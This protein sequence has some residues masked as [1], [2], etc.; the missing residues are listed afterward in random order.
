[1]DINDWME[2]MQVEQLRT[3]IQTHLAPTRLEA[4]NQSAIELLKVIFG[5]NI[6]YKHELDLTPTVQISA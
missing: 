2:A 3:W 4:I 6:L 1:M 5:F